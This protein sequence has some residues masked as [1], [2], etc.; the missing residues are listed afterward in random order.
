MKMTER[1]EWIEVGA[2]RWCN[3]CGSFQVLRGGKWRDAMVGPWPS[4]NRTD[5]SKHTES[6]EHARGY[7][8]EVYRANRAT[9]SEM[10]TVSAGRSDRQAKRRP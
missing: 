2:R 4:Y 5:M 3:E 9:D 10:T 1:H 8:K 7:R 6:D